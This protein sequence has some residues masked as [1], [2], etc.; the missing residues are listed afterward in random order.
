[1]KQIEDPKI[2]LDDPAA[3]ANLDPDG[4]GKAIETLPDQWREAESIARDAALDLPQG[5]KQVLFLGMGG[6]AIGGDFVRGLLE[7]KSEASIGVNRQYALPNYVDSETVVI[8]ASYSGNTEETLM[9]AA[10]AQRRGAHMVAVTTGGQLAEEAERYGWPLIRIPAGLQPRAAIGYSFVP[11]LVLAERLGL[12]GSVSEEL[13]ETAGILDSMVA[14]YGFDVP[15][16]DNQAKQLAVALYGKLPIIYGSESWR[17][18]AANRWKTQ[19]N[20]NS[21]GPAWWSAFPELNHNET[22]GWEAPEEVTRQIEVIMLRDHFDHER[23]KAR[24]DVTREIMEKAV[25][26]ITELWSEGESDTARLFSLVYP[27]DFVSYY[28][29]LVNGI[30]PSPVKMIDLLKS[31]LASL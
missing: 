10:E 16:E 3:V 9:A 19:I 21:K 22:V 24:M 8:A 14:R 30:D 28:L 4:M 23:V 29:A 7:S 18:V 20:E 15:Y 1:M 31:R 11:L 5:T 13:A 2:V 26:G 6:S 27:G 17:A 25:S 12:C